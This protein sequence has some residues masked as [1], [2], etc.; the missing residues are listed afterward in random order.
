[1]RPY[2][3]VQVVIVVKKGEVATSHFIW[4]SAAPLSI[5]VVL[6]VYY[7]IFRIKAAVVEST[8]N[9]ETFSIPTLVVDPLVIAVL[10]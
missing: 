1:V 6:N 5:N 9:V 10:A 3:T 7:P 8:A 4:I 2:I